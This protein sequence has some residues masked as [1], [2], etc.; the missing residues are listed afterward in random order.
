M[1][2]KQRGLGKGLQALI[3]S[4]EP[5]NEEPKPDETGVVQIDV[6]RIDPN[7]KQARRLFEK[8][9]MESLTASIA[10]HGVIQPLIVSSSEG[11]YRLIAGERRWRA[12]KMAGLEKVPAVVTQLGD[13]EEVEV[14]LIENLQREDLNPLEEAAGMKFLMEEYGLTQ[15][16]AAER[17][18][19]SRSAVANALRLLTLPSNIQ[20]LIWTGEL[21]AGHARALAGMRDTSMQERMAF[22][23]VEKGLSVREM[24]TLKSRGRK[25]GKKTEENKELAP[26]LY[27]MQERIQKAVGTRVRIMGTEKRGKITIEYYNRE[28]IERIYAFLQGEG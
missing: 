20:D 23:A 11:R 14:S 3:G 8:E 18:G 24:E 21:S 25:E 10:L 7:P 19:K 28:D 6:M 13:R 27:E 17:L 9:S 26:E 12:A 2:V 5:L 1:S 4:A 16:R 15:E 22:Q